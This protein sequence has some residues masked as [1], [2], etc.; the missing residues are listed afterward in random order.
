MPLVLAVRRWSPRVLILL[1]VVAAASALINTPVAD[2]AAPPCSQLLIVNARGSGQ[3]STDAVGDQS[4]YPQEQDDFI[5]SV[6]RYTPA[7]ISIAEYKVGQQGPLTVTIDGKKKTF[8]PYPAIDAKW[9]SFLFNPSL[10]ITDPLKSSYARSM[11]AGRDETY[12][13]LKA[14]AGKCPGEKWIIA[15][16]SQGA[17][18]V[19]DGVLKLTPSERSQIAFVA[20][21]GDPLFQYDNDS[22]CNNGHGWWVRD[23]AE[24]GNQGTMANTFG[25]PRLPY[26]PS[27]LEGRVG[28]WCN[29]D[30]GFCARGAL[31]G[32]AAHGR[33]YEN[34]PTTHLGASDNAG[35]E[36]ANA[37]RLASGNPGP[38]QNLHTIN[39]GMDVVVVF[40]TTG[41]M[42]DDIESARADAKSI[43]AQVTSLGGRV[44][45]VQFRDQGDDFVSRLE[46]GLT[47]DLDAFQNALDGLEASGG[48]DTPEATYSG[49]MTALNESQWRFGAKKLIV[50]ETDAPGKDPE[51]VTGYTL[52][53]VTRRS[54]EI[55][56][57]GVF[58]IDNC[59]C[60][61]KTEQFLTSLGAET[62]GALIDGDVTD[63]SGA[64]AR[65]LSRAS[66]RP[67]IRVAPSYLGQ[68]GVPL[69]ISVAGTFDPDSTITGY[70]WDLDGDGSYEISTTTPSASRVFPSVGT[71][72]IGVA[73]VS[74]D[75]DA[76]TA[77]SSVTITAAGQRALLPSKV[78]SL[79]AQRSGRHQVTLTWSKPKVASGLLGYRI[80]N[81]K[82]KSVAFVPATKRRA[83][84]RGVPFHTRVRW[85]VIPVSARG[86][87]PA[88]PISI[89][90][91]R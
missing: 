4:H 50:V 85:N 5:G 65:V 35:L 40:D 14:R 25:R 87:G 48:G 70:R 21:F 64:F 13:V 32:G 36:A 54:L 69:T 72:Q 79:N 62:G 20:L 22:N 44:G 31:A 26:L 86:N 76:N 39:A 78:R 38:L 71:F 88:V 43:G 10:S 68:A 67:V 2:A 57:V 91:S 59:Q 63:P 61:T 42:A 82:G 47:S 41:S 16:Y 12:A 7:G 73:A 55:D 34:D 6:R 18:A 83:V 84:L 24:C 17:Q 51:P 9:S 29:R 1:I 58:S 75:G 8:K 77:I 11:E 90:L 30:D 19:G 45:L 46:L 23:S 37:Y 15:G 66:A 56:P 74:A 52:A 80:R 60:N 49:I 28:S 53:Q 27:D 89:T 81:A 3:N 33:G